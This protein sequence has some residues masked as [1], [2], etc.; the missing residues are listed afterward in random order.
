MAYYEVHAPRHSA[1]V[2]SLK[3]ML[4]EKEKSN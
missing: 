3:Y 2:E 4:G 1:R